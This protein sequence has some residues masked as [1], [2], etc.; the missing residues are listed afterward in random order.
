MML[1]V[2][3]QGSWPEN[4]KAECKMCIPLVLSSTVPSICQGRAPFLCFSKGLRK[5]VVS[6]PGTAHTL[7]LLQKNR[8]GKRPVLF[9]RLQQ[10]FIPAYF[11]KI[12]FPATAV[13]YLPCFR[14]ALLLTKHFC[15]Q[16]LPARSERFAI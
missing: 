3:Q 10:D 6:K 4:D 16:N 5:V 15:R 2:S 1:E 8:V 12:T 7:L 13:G 9:P 11:S 14:S